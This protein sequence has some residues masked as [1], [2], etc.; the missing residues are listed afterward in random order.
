MVKSVRSFAHEWIKVA[1][2]W[3]RYGREEVIFLLVNDEV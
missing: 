2:E 3:V 1:N